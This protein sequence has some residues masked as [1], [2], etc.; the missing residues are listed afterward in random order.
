MKSTLTLAALVAIAPAAFAVEFTNSTGG[1][2][3]DNGV[4]SQTVTIGAGFTDINYFKIT[5]FTHTW[6]GDVTI[7]ITAPNASSMTV[8][9]RTGRGA[10]GFGDSTNVDG[11]YRFIAG[12]ADFWAAAAPLGSADVIPGGDYSPFTNNGDGTYTLT[13]YTMFN[14]DSSGTWTVDI[15]DGAGGDTGAFVTWS[16]DTNAVPEP[17]TMLLLG[18]GAAALVARR[19][20]NSK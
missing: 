20:K 14:G 2:I 4:I 13:D 11:D 18:A 5:G 15:A 17:G 10:S 8:I 12:G 1:A 7:T 19:R 6:I 3:P 9:A 16:L